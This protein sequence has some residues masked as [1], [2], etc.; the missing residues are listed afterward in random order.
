MVARGSGRG[1]AL[2]AV[3]RE[4]VKPERH[5]LDGGER[6]PGRRRSAAG[7]P[8]AAQPPSRRTAPARHPAP[9]RSSISTHLLS[10]RSTLGSLALVRS[11][12]AA[13][14]AD[15]P[16]LRRSAPVSRARARVIFKLSCRSPASAA[17]PFT[18]GS[19]QGAAALRAVALPAGRPL[20]SVTS[21]GSAIVT[22]S[23]QTHQACGPRPRSGA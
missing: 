3:Q 19:E 14:R 1:D 16:C 22:F 10:M 13:G 5:R 7:R 12:H 17:R 8:P 4:R 15:Q 9:T 11:K 20:G 2:S 6:G 18:A 23:P 21:R